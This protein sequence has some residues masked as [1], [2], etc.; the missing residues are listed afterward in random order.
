LNWHK[1]LLVLREIFN[2]DEKVDSYLCKRAAY[3]PKERAH[4]SGSDVFFA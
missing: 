2:K 3:S 4:I 1:K